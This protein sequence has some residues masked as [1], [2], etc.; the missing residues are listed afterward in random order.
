MST[1]GAQRYYMMELINEVDGL[2]SQLIM[3]T[4]LM[5]TADE[6]T[7]DELKNLRDTCR[8]LRIEIAEKLRD[9]EMFLSEANKT[10]TLGK[11]IFE[12]NAQLRE[13]LNGLNDVTTSVITALQAK[14]KHVDEEI[15]CFRKK[16]RA[17][18]S[19][20]YHEYS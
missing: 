20:K 10:G 18:K 15:R 17:I 12:A 6:Y 2:V 5:V 16:Q 14:M 13:H 8:K 3:Y 19:Y 9:I 11:D 1:T 7:K 4:K